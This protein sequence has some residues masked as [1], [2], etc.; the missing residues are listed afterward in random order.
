VRERHGH[1]EDD[2][3]RG[4]RAHRGPPA[5][6]WRGRRQRERHPR[7]GVLLVRLAP[8]DV[9]RKAEGAADFELDDGDCECGRKEDA[10]GKN[11]K[12]DGAPR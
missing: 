7:G 5:V 1:C 8:R 12:T 3:G 11:P 9:H 2:G 10:H 4:E 6:A